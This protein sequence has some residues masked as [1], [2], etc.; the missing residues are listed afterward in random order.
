M[1]K[2][3][4]KQR[5]G[6]NRLNN[7]IILGKENKMTQQAHEK[8]LKEMEGNLSPIT[9]RLHVWLCQQEDSDL[10]EAILKEDRTIHEA[11][12]YCYAQGSRIAIKG[13]ADVTKE[14]EQSWCREYYLKD[15]ITKQDL[16]KL[17][18]AEGERVEIEVFKEVEKIV[19]K[20][21]T[22]EEIEKYLQQNRGKGKTAQTKLDENK[23]SQIQL[24]LDL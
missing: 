1:M 11:T 3:I 19:Y 20:E 6:I 22:W 12:Q 5:K 15:K 4:E 17:P 24:G 21:P 13:V 2:A 18:P 8:L 16:K 23:D 9:E 14:M 7:L 10:L